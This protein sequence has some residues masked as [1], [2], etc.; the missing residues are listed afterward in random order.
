MTSIIRYDLLML[1]LVFYRLACFKAMSMSA[2]DW[3]VIKVCIVWILSCDS[4]WWSSISRFRNSL[5]YIRAQIKRGTF[6]DLYAL[7]P[8]IDIF[9]YPFACHTDPSIAPSRCLS[10]PFTFCLSGCFLFVDLLCALAHSLV[11]FRVRA[12]DGT[13]VNIQA[14]YTS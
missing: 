7:V 10:F 11:R 4:F 2:S 13:V 8:L 5:L 3:K 12:D 9:F 1:N 6:Y 14:N